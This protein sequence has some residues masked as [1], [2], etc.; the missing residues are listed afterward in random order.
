MVRLRVTRELHVSND[1]L[2]RLSVQ[3]QYFCSNDPHSQAAHLRADGQ[4]APL[5][6]GAGAATRRPAGEQCRDLDA[7]ALE[8]GG[9]DTRIVFSG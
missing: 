1:F 8:E 3:S 2:S 4:P 9:L 7:G 6:P 5:L